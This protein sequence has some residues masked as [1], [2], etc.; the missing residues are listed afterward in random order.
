M[1]KQ[2][3]FTMFLEAPFSACIFFFFCINCILVLGIEKGTYDQKII[4]PFKNIG[5]NQ[6]TMIWRIM[7]KTTICRSLNF[8]FHNSIQFCTVRRTVRYSYYCTV[9]VICP[10]P[11][12]PK[13]TKI[14]YF[15][16]SLFQFAGDKGGNMPA[17]LAH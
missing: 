13:N 11:S 6:L 12:F 8:I 9:S 15:C 5:R 16:K 17:H 10:S 1:A 14:I 3:K 4:P 2:A 7:K